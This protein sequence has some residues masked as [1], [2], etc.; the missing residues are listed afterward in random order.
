[1][2]DGVTLV[3]QLPARRAGLAAATAAAAA[4]STTVEEPSPLASSFEVVR[5]WVRLQPSR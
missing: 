1:M 4:S 3:G 5:G 2:G